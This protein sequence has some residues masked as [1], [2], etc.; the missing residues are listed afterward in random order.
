MPGQIPLLAQLSAYGIGAAGFGST[1]G[2][3]PIQQHTIRDEAVNR[4]R[5]IRQP[6]AA[7]KLAIGENIDADIALPL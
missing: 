4:L 7:A 5:H 2:T 3:F 6:G 1:T